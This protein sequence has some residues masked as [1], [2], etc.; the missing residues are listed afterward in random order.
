M[1]QDRTSAGL[2]FLAALIVVAGASGASA[3]SGLAVLT[4]TEKLQTKGCGKATAAIGPELR[5]TADGGWVLTAFDATIGGAS[6]AGGK[7]GRTL[8]LT[9]DAASLAV[10]RAG[11]LDAV[12]TL[13][14]GPVDT[15]TAAVKTARVKLNK[16]ST[17][18]SLLLVLSVAGDGNPLKK[19]TYRLKAKGALGPLPTTT[20]TVPTTTSTVASTTTSL[21]PTTTVATTTTSTTI[22]PTGYGDCVNGGTAACLPGEGCISVP[23]EGQT[24]GFCSVECTDTAQCPSPHSGSPRI[25]CDTGS[26]VCLLLCDGGETCPDGMD[27]VGGQICL[28][29]GPCTPVCD[30]RVCGDDGCGT[31]CGDCDPGAVCF[32]GAC[33]AGDSCA[34]RCGTFDAAASCQCDESCVES[35]DCCPDICAPGVCDGLGVCSCVPDCTERVCGSDGCFGTCGDCGAGAVCTPAG[36][37]VAG[38]S[39]VG[40]C[41]TSDAAAGCQCDGGCYA[42]GDCCADLCDP[43]VC[44]L[45][46][47][48][49][50]APDCTER[51]CGSDGCFGTCGECGAGDVCSPAAQCVS[52]SSCLGRCDSYDVSAACQCDGGCIAAGDCCADVCDA[53]VCDTASICT[54]VPDCTE[55][56]C[57]FDGCF[58][59]C[60]SCDPGDVCSGAGQCLSGTSCVG[61]CD[62]YDVN[63]PCQCDA[64][65]LGAGDCCLDLCDPGVC[66]VSP[67]CAP[68]A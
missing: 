17:T 32:E 62:T 48:C 45:D 8:T 6:G 4:G 3:A 54:C 59:E 22:A 30:G 28:F 34:G 50:C 33:L 38:D 41:G 53:G 20:S 42:R 66:D 51:A 37:C 68:P 67:F 19:G 23:F 61:R 36:Q 55:R 52:G 2:G 58:G 57:G 16:S 11:L 7:G 21:A 27:C 13:C 65:C 18:A 9:L 49:T 15:A 46:F 5:L 63:A 56:V 25:D 44:D 40:R 47:V 60:G 29:A 10:A 24:V 43:G 31:T 12:G 14:G 64:E 26:G 1:R 35:S 39:C